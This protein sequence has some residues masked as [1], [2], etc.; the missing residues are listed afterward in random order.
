MYIDQRK[1]NRQYKWQSTF[2]PLAFDVRVAA[3]M[4]A[5]KL[6]HERGAKRIAVIAE[7]RPWLQQRP[8]VRHGDVAQGFDDGARCPEG[9]LLF[10]KEVH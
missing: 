9:L 3:A 2:A 1:Y 6:L 10:T 8:A 7:S 4:R 5:A